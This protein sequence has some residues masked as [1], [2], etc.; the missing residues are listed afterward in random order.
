MTAPR[1][2]K[3]EIIVLL[4]LSPVP[5]LDLEQLLPVSSFFE[6]LDICDAYWVLQSQRGADTSRQ[7]PGVQIGVLA[8]PRLPT[9]AAADV[10]SFCNCILSR[11]RYAA[12]R[13]SK[14]PALSKNAPPVVYGF[15]LSGNA[16]GPAPYRRVL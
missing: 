12:R 7:C 3:K 9:A 13:L 16:K 5:A 11:Q 4:L 14:E 1:G 6:C 8:C 2:R 10:L 15:A